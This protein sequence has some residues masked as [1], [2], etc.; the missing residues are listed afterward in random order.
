MTDVH[1]LLRDPNKLVSACDKI[2][3]RIRQQIATDPLEDD[4]GKPDSVA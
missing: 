2:D 3:E 4:Q 1:E